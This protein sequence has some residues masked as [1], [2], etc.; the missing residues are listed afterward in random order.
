MLDKDLGDFRENLY[1]FLGLS[2]K[3]FGLVLSKL[4]STSPVGHFK[5][6]FNFAIDTDRIGKSSEKNVYLLG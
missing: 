3:N 4:N 1:N 6:F 5:F 2:A